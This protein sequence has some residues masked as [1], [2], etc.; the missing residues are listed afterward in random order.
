MEGWKRRVNRIKS[1]ACRQ[2]VG[3]RAAVVKVT[4][5]SPDNN[6]EKVRRTEVWMQPDVPNSLMYPN[7]PHTCAR[8][9]ASQRDSWMSATSE[10]RS[11]ARTVS[12]V[13]SR[14]RILR[15]FGRF[16]CVRNKRA[17]AHAR[18]RAQ[19]REPARANMKNPHVSWMSLALTW[20]RAGGRR[21]RCVQVP[22]VSPASPREAQ[23]PANI[24]AYSTAEPPPTLSP[25]PLSLLALPLLPPSLPHLSPSLGLIR[26]LRAAS[27]PPPTGV[28]SQISRWTR[29]RH[30]T[31]AAS[32]W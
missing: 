32:R 24:T 12:R 17:R 16:C 14:M 2:L 21:R 18:S 27:P 31:P 7:P 22:Q 9:L 19:R 13:G 28:A 29:R 20:F 11:H 10:P 30:A 3:A 1:Q 6:S 4:S 23:L 8:A 26:P 15:F 25:S 5:T